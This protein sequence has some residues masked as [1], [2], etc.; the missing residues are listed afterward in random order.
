MAMTTEAPA[1]ERIGELTYDAYMAEPETEG[2]YSIVNGVRMFMAEAS[3]RHQRV[4]KNISK[5]FDRYEEMSGLGVTV[6][7]PFDVLIRRFPKLQTRQ[8]DVLF[9]SYAR[10]AQADGVPVQGPLE[11]A[12]E[13]V[14]EIVLDS[15]TQRILGEKLADYVE[16][17]VSECW[18]VRPDAATVEVLRLTADGASS[19]AVY[20]PGDT[21]QYRSDY[22]VSAVFAELAVSVAEVIA[23]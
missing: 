19:I 18:V 9:V 20:G 13:L 22:F 10:L 14:V 7:A 8:T 12:P 1:P 11:A 3:Y 21:V 5:A 4:S 6:Y 23:A 15:E 17:G 16:I 2:R